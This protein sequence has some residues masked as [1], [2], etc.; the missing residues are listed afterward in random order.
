MTTVIQSQE[1][2]VLEHK[3]SSLELQITPNGQ[4]DILEIN[5]SDKDTKL[6]YLQSEFEKL[7]FRIGQLLGENTAMRDWSIIRGEYCHHA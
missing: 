6:F 5:S 7:N 3:I 2:D 1:A 4:H